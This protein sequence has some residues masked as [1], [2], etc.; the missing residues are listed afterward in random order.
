M[1]MV[2]RDVEGTQVAAVPLTVRKPNANTQ[3]GRREPSD[4][5][6]TDPAI[7]CAA[8]LFGLGA[9]GTPCPTMAVAPSSP[10]LDDRV[11]QRCRILADSFQRVFARPVIPQP[12]A[13]DRALAQALYDAPV[14]IVSHGDEPDPVFWFANR[15]AQRLWEV[16]WADFIRMPSRQS[17]ESGGHE[18]RERLL[19]RTRACGGID[20]YQG[21]RISASGRRFRIQDVAFFNLSAPSGALVGQAAVF[22]TWRHL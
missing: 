5:L 21:V 11:V 10:W 16:A 12:P 9:G 1:G 4:P 8:K 13:D 3:D 19:A 7:P 15:T 2:T 14:V 20:D 6:G 17:V 22:A 18:E